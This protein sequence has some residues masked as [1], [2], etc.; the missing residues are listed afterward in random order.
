[1][2]GRSKT[3]SLYTYRGSVL[4]FALVNSVTVR[5]MAPSPAVNLRRNGTLQSCERCRTTK[6]KCDHST[7][8]CG[9][10]LAKN[11]E[12]VYEAAPMTRRFRAA[13]FDVR[14]GRVRATTRAQDAAEQQQQQQPLP[15]VPYVPSHPRNSPHTTGNTKDGRV[16]SSSGPDRRHGLR[17]PLLPLSLLD[18]SLLHPS[19]RGPSRLP[20][21]RSRPAG[22]WAQGATGPGSQRTRARLRWT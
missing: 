1:M 14:S 19:S 5:P 3:T 18:L 10:C 12:C 15:L 2:D 11:F 16:D 17:R 7:P 4:D 22:L 8:R 21:P 6:I 13:R 9:R 20:H